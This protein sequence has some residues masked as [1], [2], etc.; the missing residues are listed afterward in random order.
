MKNK[1]SLNRPSASHAVMSPQVCLIP[2]L[3]RKAILSCPHAGSHLVIDAKYSFV[4]AIVFPKAFHSHADFCH[5]TTKAEHPG[6][7]RP[8][9]FN[10][11]STDDSNWEKRKT[12]QRNI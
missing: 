12:T 1:L 8:G 7:F 6:L 10:K 2:K 11:C 9:V 5:L 4:P 3:V